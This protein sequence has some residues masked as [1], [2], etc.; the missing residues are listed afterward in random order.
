[1]EMG[2]KHADANLD[3]YLRYI[4]GVQGDYKGTFYQDVAALPV[5]LK[6]DYDLATFSSVEKNII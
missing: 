1:M 6:L 5:R 4:R 3:M 2:L